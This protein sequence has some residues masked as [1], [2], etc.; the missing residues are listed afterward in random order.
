M[1]PSGRHQDDGTSRA[2]GSHAQRWNPDCACRVA[3]AIAEQVKNG[4]HLQQNCMISQPMVAL[5]EKLNEVA[6]A[7]LSRF[8]FNCEY[9]AFTACM[10]FRAE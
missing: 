8:F 5:L 4:I 6:P 2:N 9:R 3:E 7:G 10:P 1:A